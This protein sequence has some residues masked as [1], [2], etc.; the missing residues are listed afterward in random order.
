MQD[1][2]MD[3]SSLVEVIQLNVSE[4]EKAG[5]ICRCG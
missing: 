5:V 4:Q 3:L 2:G 1:A